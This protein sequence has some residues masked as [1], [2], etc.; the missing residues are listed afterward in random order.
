MDHSLGSLPEEDRQIIQ[1]LLQEGIARRKEEEHFFTRYAY[2]VREGSRKYQLPEDD[3]LDAY[4]DA[5]LSAI[6][7]IS[8]GTFEGRSTLK[9]WLFQIFHN[10]CVDLLRK[11]TTNK[12]AIHQTAS[13]T[14][15]LYQLSDNAKSIV[16][17]L[18]DKADREMLRQKLNELGNTCRQLLLLSADGYNDREIASVLDYKNADVVKTSRLRCLD[19]LRQLYHRL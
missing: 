6:D 8:K 9:T 14:D 5:I 4:T 10:K 1:G 19:K 12:N 2:F 3:A 13:I 7:K 15:M 11:K 18:A 16:Q 17:K